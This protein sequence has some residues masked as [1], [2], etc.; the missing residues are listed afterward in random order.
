[1]SPLTLMDMNQIE[2]DVAL[3]SGA[4]DHNFN[5]VEKALEAGADVNTELGIDEST[6]LCIISEKDTSLAP[7]IAQ[8][9]LDAG[10]DVNKCTTEGFTPLLLAAKYHRT[11]LVKVFLQAGADVNKATYDG[12]TALHVDAMY[13]ETEITGLLLDLGADANRIN[14]AGETP[15]FQAVSKGNVK[16]VKLLVEHGASINLKNEKNQAPMD[17]TRDREVIKFLNTYSKIQFILDSWILWQLEY[18]SYAQWLPREMLDE[19][20]ALT[21]P[22]EHKL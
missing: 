19:T 18:D 16:K 13:K 10:A 12:N 2:V 20:L 7:K 6:P 17:L 9:I 14:G 15:L 11:G 4:Y 8:K 1:M 22:S 21:I 3:L 5:Q